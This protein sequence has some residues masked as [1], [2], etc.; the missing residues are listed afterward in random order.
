MARD[1]WMG[2]VFRRYREG[3]ETGITGL[4][5]TCFRTFRSWGIGP[6]DWLGFEESDYGF[7]RRN[8]LVAEADGAIVGHVQVV[9]R[10][11]H[12]GSALLD[13]CG[14]ANVSTHPEYNPGLD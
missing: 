9:H 10:R 5:R 2:I 3:D 6:E 4:L 13:T 11:L 14:I 8:A 12:V 1:R 7:N